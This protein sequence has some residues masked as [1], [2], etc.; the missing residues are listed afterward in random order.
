MS[1]CASSG[2]IGDVK[3]GEELK[4]TS[5]EAGLR[6]KMDEAERSFST[7]E[8]IIKDPELQDY[9]DGLVCRLSADICPDIRL[10]IV[11]IPYFNASMSPNG[12]MQVWTGL[13]LRVENEAQLATVLAHELVH[14]RKRHSIRMWNSARNT[15][16]FL[17]FFNLTLGG[18]GY[19]LVGLA[20]TLGATGSIQA[21]S[22]D[23]EREAD[24]I[25]QDS[26]YAAGY[27]PSESAKLWE[28]IK[29]EYDAGERE[30]TA[31]FFAS[32]PPAEDRVEN[33]KGRAE[34]YRERS[35]QIQRPT[36]NRFRELV[37]ARWQGW[38]RDLIDTGSYKE[39]LFVIDKLEKR[40]F[41]PVA[42]AFY[43]GDVY[44]RRSEEGDLE[45]AKE[46]YLAAAASPDAPPKTYK[47]LGLV[48]KRQKESGKAIEFFEI[49]LA[50]YPEASD[51]FL[52][53]SYIT[54]L[55]ES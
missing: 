14:Y 39:T 51:R 49:Y 2:P 11:K 48:A 46:A 6:M 50:R 36:D 41:S 34:T 19:G 30:A 45:K 26:L 16:D 53:E 27:D 21:Y 15:T 5:L 18:V 22:R 12:V 20:A 13:M 28:N 25:G 35:F 24:E 23:L 44:R 7:S 29:G 1:A 33:L 10:Y 9:L 31:I 37:D 54:Q 3:P 32:H 47:N 40:N 42:L 52:V 55:R 38:I 17:A 43:R 4:L 8:L